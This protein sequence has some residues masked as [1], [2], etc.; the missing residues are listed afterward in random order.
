MRS[1][2]PLVALVLACGGPASSTT[3]GSSTSGSS[4]STSTTGDLI[5][6]GTS[7][8]ASTGLTTSTTTTT[9][10]AG[11]DTTLTATAATATGDP[12]GG[13]A[14]GGTVPV[15][16]EEAFLLGLNYPWR[17]YG[18]DFG[19]NA[20]G[21]YGVH[22]QP[23][24]Y[25]GDLDQIDA[26]RAGVVRWFVFTDGRA[27]ITFAGDGTPTGLGDHVVED[28]TKA[29]ELARARGLYLVPVLFDFHWMFWSKQENGVTLGGRSDTLRDPAKRDAL[30]D[31]VVTPLLQALA[32]E[33]AI[34]AWEVMNEPEWSIADLPEASPDGGADAVPLADFYA[35]AAGAADRV[36]AHTGAYATLGSASLKWYRVWT[37]TFAAERGYPP[38]ALDFYQTHY[39]PWM[40]GQAWDGHPEL[41][42]V[43]FAP[44]AQDYAAL[45]LDRPMVVGE[46][47]LSD[48]A[49][50]RLDDLLARG[51]A[52]AWPW[53]LT[54]DY[55]VDAAGMAAWADAH[56]DLVDLPPP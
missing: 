8:G 6:A 44:N 7:A 56:A 21:T 9:V 38:L 29:A 39:Y 45:G 19:G 32:D 47:I 52:G 4:A 37:P 54:S 14:P 15:G 42:T 50:A 17:S 40:D 46:F 30:L 5:T 34:L 51:Y 3:E 55:S 10:T 1:P 41:G 11:T 33:P 53:S 27:G 43:A 28:L 18:G 48:Q 12:S 24:A 25:G 23:D 36:H 16:G 2:A 22:T 13:P 20:W 26:M 35:F 49:G 31:A